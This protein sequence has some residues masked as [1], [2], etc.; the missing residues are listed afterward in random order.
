MNTGLG[1]S[2]VTA[3]NH[4]EHRVRVFLSVYISFSVCVYLGCSVC[5]HMCV[6][7]E[8]CTYF[9]KK[10]THT[11]TQEIFAL[12]ERA[13]F[14]NSKHTH[15]HTPSKHALDGTYEVSVDEVLRLDSARTVQ[16]PPKHVTA[17]QISTPNSR[18]LVWAT[19]REYTVS[20]PPAYPREYLFVCVDHLHPVRGKTHDA[21]FFQSKSVLVHF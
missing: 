6:W 10:N 9:G 7:G 13:R 2:H 19:C 17:L 12:I 16:P 3:C 8:K 5:M 4:T 21:L 11:H 15:T 1:S 14:A 18:H 20:T